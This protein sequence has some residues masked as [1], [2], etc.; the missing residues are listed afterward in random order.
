MGKDVEQ[1]V[2]RYE[3]VAAGLDG[4]EMGPSGAEYSEGGPREHLTRGSVAARILLAASVLFLLL[5][6]WSWTKRVEFGVIG[7]AVKSEDLVESRLVDLGVTLP[8]IA[9]ADSD[10]QWILDLG[11]ATPEPDGTW[12]VDFESRIVFESRT[13]SPETL[14]LSFYPFL[15]GDVIEREI[16][17]ETSLE[18]TLFTLIDG[19]NSVTVRLDGERRQIIDVRCSRMDSPKDLG[20]GADKRPL[21]AKLLSVRVD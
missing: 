18:T 19:I 17:V 16:E 15:H 7:E 20:M 8:M 13:G 9:T 11:F 21:C 12:I 1:Q 5:G 10:S 2:P 6:S 14:E 3:P 4:P